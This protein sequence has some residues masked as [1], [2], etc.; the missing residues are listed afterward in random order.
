M[1][2]A[3]L[4]Q[5]TL[6]HALQQLY[7]WELNDNSLDGARDVIALCRKSIQNIITAERLSTATR[8]TTDGSQRCTGHQFKPGGNVCSV[9][10][11]STIE[12]YH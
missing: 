9:C 12:G 7:R 2:S 8:F 4:S 10:G 1:E 5:Q 3:Q 6:K 11:W